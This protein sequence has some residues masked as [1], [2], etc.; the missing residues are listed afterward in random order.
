MARMKRSNDDGGKDIATYT[1]LG[2]MYWREALDKAYSPGIDT[3]AVCPEM[4][5]LKGVKRL[6]PRH[7]TRDKVLV[8]YDR[9]YVFYRM[10]TLFA[11]KLGVVIDGN[12]DDARYTVILAGLK[13]YSL[14]E[15]ERERQK[16]ILLQAELLDV[17]FPGKGIQHWIKMLS[18]DDKRDKKEDVTTT[19]N[20][21]PVTTKTESEVLDNDDATNLVTDTVIGLV[22]TITVDSDNLGISEKR[23]RGRPKKQD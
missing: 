2:E 14:K 23:G 9:E 10:Y 7:K 3:V 6:I 17:K 8:T 5:G 11:K 18:D 21:D 16:E 19:T 1:D 20:V 22:D 12:F 13:E 15:F 4:L